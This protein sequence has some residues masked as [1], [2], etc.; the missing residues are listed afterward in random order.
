MPTTFKNLELFS[1][2]PHRLS[3]ARQ[4]QALMSELFDNP[5]APGTRYIGLVELR[6]TITGR[7]IAADEAALWVLRDAITAQLLHPP[8]PGMLVDL[9]GRAWADMSFIRF[10]PAESTDRGRL[11]SLAY[12]ARFLRFRQYPQG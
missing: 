4:G 3:V 2:G 7:L 6:I 11:V 10:Q 9:H 12:T 8:I 5:P 1:S